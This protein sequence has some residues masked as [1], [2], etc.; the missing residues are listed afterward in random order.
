MIARITGT[1]EQIDDGEALIA[2]PGGVAHQ[3][4]V[5]AYL[6][7]RLAAQPAGSA[8]TLHTLEYF[9]SQNQGASFIP[10]LI[11]F[12]SVAERSFFELLTSVKGLG[13]KRA[14]RAM[15]GEPGLVA[16]AI[17]DRDTRALQRLPEIGP[18]LAELIVHEL[19]NKVEPY[20]RLGLGGA[21]EPG[22]IAPAA[23]APEVEAKPARKPRVR[24]GEPAPAV[25][26]PAP[27]LAALPIRQTVEVLI[28][29][30]ET[31][32]EAERLVARAIERARAGGGTP[33]TTTQ[34]L[35]TAAYAAR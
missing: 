34:E 2:L 27:A 1:L 26:T 20:I 24:L 16:R 29:L 3:V 18:K 35:V 33:P 6:A 22:P 7:R 13:N 17:Y 32:L 5:P 4:L 31:P 21:S 30:G 25:A 14:L 23:A 11:G 10:R 9:E 15:A 28:T 8:V 19:K 12:A